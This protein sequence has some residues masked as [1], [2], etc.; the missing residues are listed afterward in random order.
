MIDT[1]AAALDDLIREDGMTIEVRRI[2]GAGPSSIPDTRWR[3]DADWWTVTLRMHGRSFTTPFGMGRA[4]NGEAPTRRAVLSCMI[5]D[6]M[7]FSQARSMS[8]WLADYGME[9]GDTATATWRAV[10]NQTTRLT[11][12]LGSRCPAYMT[13][14]TD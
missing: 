3:H 4:H 9:D 5:S 6:A 13:A 11:R 7:G 2:Y 1:T 12:F 14:D 8:E 10:K